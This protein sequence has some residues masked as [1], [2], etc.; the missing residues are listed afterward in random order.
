MESTRS[1]MPLHLQWSGS[2]TECRQSCA[3]PAS[4]RCR[5]MHAASE[6][7]SAYSIQYSSAVMLYLFTSAAEAGFSFTSLLKCFTKYALLTIL[8]VNGFVLDIC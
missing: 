3:M 2:A 5:A 7:N 8:V 4:P 1:A 6:H